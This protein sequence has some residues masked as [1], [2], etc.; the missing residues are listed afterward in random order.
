MTM[1]KP[2]ITF[3]DIIRLNEHD[4]DRAYEVL[5]Y[6]LVRGHIVKEVIIG[7]Q[8]IY[9]NTSGLQQNELILEQII[10]ADTIAAEPAI[11]PKRKRINQG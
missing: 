7:G 8:V 2:V 3:Q 1:D 9:H 10:P 11:R 4:W 5:N 6:H